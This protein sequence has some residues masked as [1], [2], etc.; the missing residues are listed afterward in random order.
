[1]DLGP[2]IIANVS[3]SCL[4]GLWGNSRKI[5]FGWAFAISFFLSPVAGL[6][7]T[8]L[9]RKNSSVDFVKVKEK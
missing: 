9:S 6:I 4:V 5:G 3:V 1:M 2:I 8:L 7:A